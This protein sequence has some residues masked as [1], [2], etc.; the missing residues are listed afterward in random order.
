[1]SDHLHEPDDEGDVV[2]QTEL[3]LT[4]G[5]SPSG[6]AGAGPL[7][8]DG[9]P[10][11]HPAATT[12]AGTGGEVASRGGDAPAGPTSGTTGTGAGTGA[13]REGADAPPGAPG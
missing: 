8:P 4:E 10:P 9:P 13:R 6:P 11:G 1:M 3:D 7:E 12:P 5:V 2:D